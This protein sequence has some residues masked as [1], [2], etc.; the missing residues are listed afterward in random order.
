[1]PGPIISKQT[2]TAMIDLSQSDR[3]NFLG[4]GN[5]SASPKALGHGQKGKRPNQLRTLLG[6]RMARRTNVG[7]N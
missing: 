2:G 7:Y 4:Q 1:M 3:I 6:Q 5:G